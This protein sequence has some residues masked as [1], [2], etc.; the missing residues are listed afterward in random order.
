MRTN[1]PQSS[2]LV[3]TSTLPGPAHPPPSAQGP[4]T[5]AIST[6][7][8]NFHVR[9]RRSAIPVRVEPD[10]YRLRDY[11]AKRRETWKREALQHHS[12]DA[13]RDEANRVAWNRDT[14]QNR[15]WLSDDPPALNT[16]D[17]SSP[18][19]Y[20]VEGQRH[21]PE[22]HTRAVEQADT[23][24]AGE[25]ADASLGVNQSNSYT[26]TKEDHP[27]KPDDRQD[28]MEVDGSVNSFSDAGKTTEDTALREDS[29][30]SA[31][32]NLPEG[33]DDSGYFTHEEENTDQS[34]IDSF[35]RVETNPSHTSGARLRYNVFSLSG[36]I[37]A[38]H[39]GMLES[40]G[41]DSEVEWNDARS[42]ATDQRGTRENVSP[43]AEKNGDT[44][45]QDALYEGT[46]ASSKAEN[47]EAN[48]HTGETSIECDT[49]ADGATANAISKTL[50]PSLEV[51]DTG[52]DVSSDALPEHTNTNTHQQDNRVDHRESLQEMLGT[53]EPYS[54]SKD[55]AHE[56]DSTPAGDRLRAGQ[57]PFTL[58]YMVGLTPL[59]RITK[60]WGLPE[61]SDEE[62]FQR[63]AALVKSMTC[64]WEAY[65]IE[66]MYGQTILSSAWLQPG[67][68][69]ELCG[70]IKLL[71]AAL[72]RIQHGRQQDGIHHPLDAAAQ[73]DTRYDRS[74]LAT[75]VPVSLL[76]DM[77]STFAHYSYKKRKPRQN[78]V[79]TALK[80]H[81]RQILDFLL[82]E[83]D[84]SVNFGDSRITTA[85]NDAIPEWCC[86]GLV[87]SSIEQLHA[88]ENTHSLHN[89]DHP[90]QGTPPDIG[91]H[92]GD[93]KNHAKNM[94]RL[95]FSDESGTD[96]DTEWED[97]ESLD[98]NASPIETSSK[99]W[100]EGF[101]PFFWPTLP[102]GSIVKCD[103]MPG[104]E[105]WKSSNLRDLKGDD[106]MAYIDK[107]KDHFDRV[108]EVTKTILNNATDKYEF[109]QA[110]VEMDGTEEENKKS[111]LEEQQ[112]EKELWYRDYLLMLLR[113]MTLYHRVWLENAD[114]KD[115]RLREAMVSMSSIINTTGEVMTIRPNDAVTFPWVTGTC[116]LVNKLNGC[117]LHDHGICPLDHQYKGVICKSF[118]GR[119]AC[120]MGYSK[121]RYVHPGGYSSLPID[122]DTSG[123]T[124]GT[125]I[126]EAAT[127]K[128][129]LKPCP[130]VNKPGGCQDRNNC[131]YG[132]FNENRKC[133]AFSE[134][135][136]CQ[137]GDRCSFL[138][139][140]PDLTGSGSSQPAF[141]AD[142]QRNLKP[143]LDQ[144]LRTPGH[145]GACGWVNK[146]PN[147]CLKGD[148][149]RFNHSLAG[150]PCPDFEATASCPRA[151]SCPLLHQGGGRGHRQPPKQPHEAPPTPT[152]MTT[153]A[154]KRPRT[155]FETEEDATTKFSK[156][157]RTQGQHWQDSK[158][159]ANAPVGPKGYGQRL[160]TSH[161]AP[162]IP[163]SLRGAYMS[164]L[165][166][167]VRAPATQRP[168][169]LDL[170]HNGQV[171]RQ[172]TAIAQS[173]D[174]FSFLGAAN[175]VQY[176]PAAEVQRSQPSIPGLPRP[177]AG[178]DMSGGQKR[179]RRL[180]EYF[181]QTSDESSEEQNHPLPNGKR[182]KKNNDSARQGNGND[183]N[184]RTHD[185]RGGHGGARRRH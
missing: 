33:W 135:K 75:L 63:I 132:H 73:S 60:L 76:E 32:E 26:D 3:P 25:M 48:A 71:H 23:M 149:C 43:A 49:E 137:F 11:E 22:L 66:N 24:R 150:H 109:G 183:H 99:C 164:H 125:G 151:G 8:R 103:L 6:P 106:F 100:K 129:G 98:G 153:S 55:E 17:F 91:D 81:V 177:E 155:V 136:S 58:L 37:K 133:R 1:E 131:P 62:C 39:Y 57:R 143:L 130:H 184:S 64:F 124:E 167:T 115:P 86:D 13:E 107:H 30:L 90:T 89:T 12:D 168:A 179:K 117:K 31:V 18:K 141:K 5:L 84:N 113:R 54:H 102:N 15:L 83:T 180:E 175:S 185:R 70:S 105:P 172:P 79:V 182:T 157:P 165:D 144:V 101:P 35:G 121:C 118:S 126:A 21:Q 92:R 122:S 108:V 46:E 41:Q 69:V 74:D 166:T 174:A 147:G 51:D 95:G 145:L 123:A 170:Q 154:L 104:N 158:P 148:S 142:Q 9:R 163:N 7:K 34:D 162:N 56:W 120:K 156:R 82:P 176:R 2:P 80:Y 140:E 38:E 36:L 160:Q 19:V 161:S 59:D 110:D 178:L 67:N 85:V 152:M 20:E 88:L 4:S 68:R 44:R 159:P 173:P 146:P 116:G 52:N 27:P 53:L 28:S 128:T 93:S 14:A 112:A 94:D 138:H 65:K 10:F 16:F 134:R 77:V 169:L 111:K 119:T 72:R 29:Q 50:Q 127:A 114:R 97:D 45:S 42:L 139:R 87:G 78:A 171:G 40:F 47:L 61:L 96:S 181:D